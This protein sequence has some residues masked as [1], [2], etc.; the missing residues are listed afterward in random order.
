M[1]SKAATLVATFCC[2]AGWPAPLAQATTCK[3][4]PGSS[5]N[6]VAIIGD[7]YTAGSAM[8]GVD[9][10]SWPSV[11]RD[12]L[13]RQ[14]IPVQFTIAADR[15][16]GYAKAGGKGTVFADQ[17]PKAVSSDDRL[18]VLFGSLNDGSIPADH[19][20]LAV[21]RTLAGVMSSAPGARVLVIGPS[22]ATASPPP[23]VLRSRDIVGREARAAGAS[24]VDPLSERWFVDNPQLIGS[25]GIHPTDIGHAYLAEKIGPHIVQQLGCEPSH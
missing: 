6:E 21:R 23:Q 10:M 9:D 8:G 15:G 3:T 4:S 13:D 2:L 1:L 20:E 18:V 19:L 17:I 7:S 12:Q 5:A 22:W 25:D 16:S 24:F 14:G 11:T